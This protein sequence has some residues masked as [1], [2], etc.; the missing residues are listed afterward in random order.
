[1]GVIVDGGICRRPGPSFMG[2]EGLEDVGRA[3]AEIS[4]PGRTIVCVSIMLVRSVAA[5]GP[6]LN[7]N[8]CC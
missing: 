8:M 7:T 5:I 1:M 2:I 4:S 6:L 3:S